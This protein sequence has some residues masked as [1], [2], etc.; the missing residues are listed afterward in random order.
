MFMSDYDDLKKQSEAIQIQLNEMRK[1]IL[2][3]RIAINETHQGMGE[4]RIDEFRDS[5]RQGH[6]ENM[7]LYYSI[8]ISAWIGVVGNFFGSHR[9]RKRQDDFCLS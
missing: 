7:N 1:E 3:N 4:I 6:R 5:I 2:Q 8:F 9:L